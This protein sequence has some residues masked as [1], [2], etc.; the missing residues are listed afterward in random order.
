[1]L[2]T[3]KGMTIRLPCRDIRVISRNTQGVR[4][5]RLEEGDKI[6]AVASIVK[7]EDDKQEELKT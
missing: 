2:M 7:E 4:M 5:V 3:N 6:A 1:M